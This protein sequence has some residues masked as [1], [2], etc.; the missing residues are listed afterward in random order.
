MTLGTPLERQ[1]V[2]VRWPL[3]T[4]STARPTQTRRSRAG[5]RDAQAAIVAHAA[6]HLPAELELDPDDVAHA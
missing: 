1:N 3:R 4:G 2:T 6:Y 5:D